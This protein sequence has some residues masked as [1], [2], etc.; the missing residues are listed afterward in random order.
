M[1]IKIILSVF[2][3]G[4]LLVSC[5][6]KEKWPEEFKVEYVESCTLSFIES[7]E[8]S[9]GDLMSEV[10]K[11]KLDELAENSCSCMYESMKTM[12]DSAEEASSR[13][14]NE[15]ADEVIANS[16]HCEATDA[17]IDDLLVK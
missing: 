12:Y 1:K 3:L 13:D 9:L 10:N 7:F 11:E 2:I 8:A 6:E 17:Q 14:S 16:L 15:V 4:M 5:S